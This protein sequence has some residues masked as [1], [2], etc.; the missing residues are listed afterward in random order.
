MGGGGKST[1]ADR[2]ERQ[3]PDR[4]SPAPLH[5]QEQRAH[6]AEADQT[7]RRQQYLRDFDREVPDER[8]R[9]A[10]IEKSQREQEGGRERRRGE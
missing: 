4:G 10:D 1:K 3:P 7:A 8:Q 9:D 6:Q 5:E 2:E